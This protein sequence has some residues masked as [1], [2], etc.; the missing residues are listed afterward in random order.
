MVGNSKQFPSPQPSQDIITYKSKV[1]LTT[2]PDIMR[3]MLLSHSMSVIPDFRLEFC[4]KL[5][6]CFRSHFRVDS[7]SI[8]MSKLAHTY[9]ILAKASP[10]LVIR[11]Y[12][13]VILRSILPWL[14]A[15]IDTAVT[16]KDTKKKKA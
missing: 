2:Q 6:D 4:N 1:C 16:P 9:A 5:H 8:Q 13:N 15:K 10:F 7:Q 3:I 11:L 12:S 14:A